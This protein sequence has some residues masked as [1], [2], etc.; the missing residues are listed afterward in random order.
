MAQN[1]NFFGG[2]NPMM[3]QGRS[4]SPQLMV[5]TTV[6][7]HNMNTMESEQGGD[8]GLQKVR[9]IESPK[10]GPSSPKG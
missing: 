7:R 10:Q 3:M 5:D 2:N 6:K 9:R 4:A 8:S 1:S